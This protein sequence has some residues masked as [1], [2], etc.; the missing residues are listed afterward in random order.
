MHK[1]LHLLENA[2]VCAML[3]G[4]EV[5]SFV[6]LAGRVSGFVITVVI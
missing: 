4:R 3:V 1:I 2:A 5:T 6:D